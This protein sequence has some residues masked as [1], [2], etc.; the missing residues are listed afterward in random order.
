M[1]ILQLHIDA[2]S[3]VCIPRKCSNPSAT[4]DV[5]SLKFIHSLMNNSITKLSIDS[6]GLAALDSNYPFIC[7]VD[8]PRLHALATAEAL[9]SSLEMM[10][11]IRSCQHNECSLVVLFGWNQVSFV[12]QPK[13]FF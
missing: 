10:I 8:Q 7:S 4:T 2:T 11:V 12:G 6:F 9:H 3:G 1:Q 13:L 5:S